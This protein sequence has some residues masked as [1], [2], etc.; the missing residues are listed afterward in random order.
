[1]S[2]RQTAKLLKANERQFRQLLLDKGVMYYLGGTLVPYQHHI[3]AGRFEVKTGTSE[4]NQHAFTQARF[5][6]KGMQWVAGLWA[7]YQMGEVA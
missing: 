5:T 4:R 3:D 7:A 1:M 6:P 2:F